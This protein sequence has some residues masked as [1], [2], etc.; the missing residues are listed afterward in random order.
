MYEIWTPNGLA[1][2]HP[3]LEG[4]A[5]YLSRAAEAEVDVFSTDG[6]PAM[7]VVIGRAAPHDGY[8]FYQTY[9]VVDVDVLREAIA[10]VEQYDSPLANDLRLALCEP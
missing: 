5:E 3:D 8:K 6:N 1:S 2:E 10:I 7:R 9:A 4:A